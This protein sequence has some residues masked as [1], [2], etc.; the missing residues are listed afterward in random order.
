MRLLTF[1]L[2]PTIVVTLAL[3]LPAS[4][5]AQ[6]KN[7]EQDLRITVG[8]FVEDHPEGGKLAGVCA[9]DNTRNVLNCDIHNGLSDWTVTEITLTLTWAPYGNDNKRYYRVPVSIAPLNTE[10][11]SVRLGLQLPPDDVVGTRTMTH[12]AWL[13]AGARG[14]P[15]W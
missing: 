9:T 1:L 4:S 15:R 14:T 10:A 3:L 13:I 12:W 5:W 8:G 6:D 11:V 7:A 2:R